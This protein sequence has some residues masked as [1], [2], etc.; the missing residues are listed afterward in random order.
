MTVSHSACWVEVTLPVQWAWIAALGESSPANSVFPSFAVAKS[1]AALVPALAATAMS[2]WAV[3]FFGI[4]LPTHRDPIQV[5]DRGLGRFQ[6][7]LGDHLAARELGLGLT[8]LLGPCPWTPAV[9]VAMAISRSFSGTLA[10]MRRTARSYSL[11]R[12]ERT[13][14]GS[15]RQMGQDLGFAAHVGPIA[16]V[17]HTDG[18][19]GRLDRQNAVRLL[20]QIGAQQFQGLDN[21]AEILDWDKNIPGKN[22]L[23]LSCAFVH[24][25][26]V[27]K[28]RRT[29]GFSL[30]DPIEPPALGQPGRA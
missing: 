4:E 6:R 12:P 16:G 11:F 8:R 5:V 2:T 7:P 23:R 21:L 24:F 10:T 19:L 1:S 20:L 29:P 26:L 25:L 9:N 13:V 18:A 28:D 14:V 17:F 27:D 30:I 3:S 22:L 15:R